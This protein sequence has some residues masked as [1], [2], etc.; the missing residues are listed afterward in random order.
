MTSTDLTPLIVQNLG[1]GT[2]KVRRITNEEVIE[3]A[4]LLLDWLPE[5]SVLVRGGGGSPAGAIR[6]TP[7][8]SLG[9][10]GGD[11]IASLGPA[12]MRTLLELPELFDAKAALNHAHLFQQISNI[13]WSTL[14]DGRILAREGGQFV[15]IPTPTGGGSG[16][17]T[18]GLT[19]PLGEDLDLDGNR[20]M[21]GDV[22]VLKVQGG[23]LYIL[24]KEVFTFDVTGATEGMVPRF[25][26]DSG[27]Y[28]GENPKV[29]DLRGETEGKFLMVGPNGGGVVE[30][31]APSG[32]SGG[33]ST[34]GSGSGAPGSTDLINDPSTS[35]DT[36]PTDPTNGQGFYRTDLLRTFVFRDDLPIRVDDNAASPD[37][38]GWI[39]VDSR[40]LT[41]I[42]QG[43]E[44][45]E[46]ERYV[47]GTGYGEGIYFPEDS[48]LWGFQVNLG[49]VVS[50]QL[51]FRLNDGTG[52]LSFPRNIDFRSS[53]TRFI[54]DQPMRLMPAGSFL[55]LFARDFSTNVPRMTAIFQIRQFFAAAAGAVE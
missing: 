27:E 28:E 15:W 12:D 53:A 5:N 14:Q 13:D 37:I 3:V 25:S 2:G 36:F 21:D 23:K 9:R 38:S 6:I 4:R 32:G 40:D 22:E 55:S 54:S 7:G 34:G 31:D 43:P 48:I 17:S 52:G 47:V 45:G 42:E 26:E 16:G 11:S 24:Q 44:N 10:L 51:N 30:V 1:E 8:Q 20:I 33:S 46:S 19:N 18:S 49:N 41:T 39:S 50:G 29:T 35:G